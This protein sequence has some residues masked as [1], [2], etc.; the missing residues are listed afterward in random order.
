[1]YHLLQLITKLQNKLI[2]SG[3]MFFTS[4]CNQNPTITLSFSSLFLCKKKHKPFVTCFFDITSFVPSQ[5]ALL[6]K[7]EKTK[8]VYFSSLH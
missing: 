4:A 1:M 2:F 7:F 5:L 6:N 8:T 3:Y